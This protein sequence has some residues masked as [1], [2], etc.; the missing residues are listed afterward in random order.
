MK[1]KILA[2]NFLVLIIIASTNAFSKDFSINQKSGPATM[3]VLELYTSEGC[4]SCP[5]AERYLKEIIDQY[6]DKKQFIPLAFHVDYWDYIGWEDPFSDPKHGLRQRDAAQRNQLNS[7]YTPQFILYGKDFPAFKN[8]PEAIG[9]INDIKPRASIQVE[10]TLGKT[11]QLDTSI[12]INA[13]D[14]RVKH[15]ANIY[16]AISENNLSSNIT[17]GEN[18]GIQLHHNH[19]V[20]HFIGPFTLQGQDKLNIKQ[21]INLDKQWKLADLNLIVYAQD[22]V[23]GTTHQAI[24]VP[25]KS[26]NADK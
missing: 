23:D 24:Q 25:L 11:N 10:T 26:L 5:A 13:E 15:F 18:E 8:I 6:A 12:T 21:K 16:I 22:S 4:S 7:L 20:R 17:D 2:L 9:I 19:V 14:E 3:A 1:S